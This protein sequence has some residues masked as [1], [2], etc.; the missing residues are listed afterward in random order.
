M[1]ELQKRFGAFREFLKLADERNAKN[2]ATGGS[3][4][5]HG[6]TKFADLSQEEFRS[7]YLMKPGYYQPRVHDKSTKSTYSKVLSSSSKKNVDYRNQGAITAV[8]N[9]GECGGCWAISATQAME[10]FGQ[11]QAK[12]GLIPLSIQQTCS[13]TYEYNGCNGGNPQ[14]AYKGIMALGGLSDSSTYPFLADCSSCSAGASKERKYVVANGYTN[15]DKGS[16]QDVL[17]NHGPPAIA[18]TAEFWNTYV[19]GVMTYCQGVFLDHAVQAVG[20]TQVGVD[21]P[22]WIVRNSWGANWG[23]NGYI[24]LSMDAMNGDLCKLQNDISY[25][26]ILRTTELEEA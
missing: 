16:L 10:S 21:I 18:V 13:C 7:S 24:Y 25:P 23:E 8:N 6:V 3:D 12:Y 19:G 1:D 15:A 2:K 17:D 26:N 22:Y 9:Q 5:V 4:D 14:D 20:Y 11:L